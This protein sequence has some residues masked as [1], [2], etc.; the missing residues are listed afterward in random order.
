M[1]FKAIHE[2]ALAAAAPPPT[3]KIWSWRIHI[4]PF[5]L[6]LH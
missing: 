1:Q 2:N 3:S 6:M 4:G 5:P